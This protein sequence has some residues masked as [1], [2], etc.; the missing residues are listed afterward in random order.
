MNYL[1]SVIPSGVTITVTGASTTSNLWAVQEQEG[2]CSESG[3]PPCEGLVFT[4]DNTD[5]ASENRATCTVAVLYDVPDADQPAEPA[6]E[7]DSAFLQL[8]GR[9]QCPADLDPPCTALADSI[10]ADNQ[11]IQLLPPPPPA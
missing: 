1:G 7:P 2:G 10:E 11:D 4:S 6:P 8:S 5:P 9:M 3:D